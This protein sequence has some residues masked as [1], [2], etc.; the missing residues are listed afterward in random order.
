[1]IVAIIYLEKSL[2]CTDYNRSSVYSFYRIQNSQY[3]RSFGGCSRIFPV[4]IPTFAPLQ[5][6]HYQVSAILHHF[7]VNVDFCWFS[8]IWNFAKFSLK[9]GPNRIFVA[10][11]FTNFCQNCREYQ[12]LPE[13]SVF[14][15][16]SRL[17]QEFS[18]NF[19]GNLLILNKSGLSL[20]KAWKKGT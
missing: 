15:A 10:E 13:V 16:I 14:R 20:L 17:F 7:F 18:F 4:G 8:Q 19:G 1:M 11:I 3:L 5:S 12:K 2:Q 6:Q 9:P